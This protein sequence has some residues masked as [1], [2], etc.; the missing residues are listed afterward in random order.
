MKDN[1]NNDVSCNDVS[2][3]VVVDDNEK[4]KLD[5]QEVLI[6]IPSFEL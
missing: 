5:I 6:N 3:N 4:R 2:C 1:S